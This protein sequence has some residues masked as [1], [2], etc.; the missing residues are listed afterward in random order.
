MEEHVNT[1]VTK[2]L[3]FT[4]HMAD[5]AMVSPVVLEKTV[6]VLIF[7]FNFKEICTIL[8]LYNTV[9]IILMPVK[10]RYFIV[11]DISLFHS[12]KY[13]AYR[14]FLVKDISLFLSVK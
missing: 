13:H 3:T 8:E 6:L 5:V 1:D 11:K 9:F 14:D 12:V 2:I 4:F 7:N 10:Y